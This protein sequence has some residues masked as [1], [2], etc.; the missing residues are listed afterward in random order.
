M[1][2]RKPIIVSIILAVVAAAMLLMVSCGGNTDSEAYTPPQTYTMTFVTDGGTEIEPISAIG[3]SMIFAPSNPTKQGSVFSGWYT[4]DKFTGD[5]V[6]IPGIMPNENVTYYAKFD[7]PK[8]EYS[9]IYEFNI[10]KAPHTGE[11][12]NV[13]VEAGSAVTVAD[14]NDYGAVGYMFMGWSIY[15]SGL[16]TDVKQEGQYNPGDEITVTDKNITLY[17]QWAVEY[18]DLRGEN[19]DKIYVYAPMI[20]RGLEA[21]KL[22]RED[23]GDKKGFVK[24]GF[25]ESAEE[26]ASGYDEFTFF[27]VDGAE[28]TGRLY[29]TRKY[30]VADGMQGQYAQYDYT[31][32]TVR[33]EYRMALDGFGYA[34]YISLAGDTIYVSASGDYEYDEEHDDYEFTFTEDTD[35]DD[36][37]PRVTY[38]NIVKCEVKDTEFVGV[39]SLLGLESNAYVNNDGFPYILDL[40]GYGGAQLHVF[41]DEGEEELLT[42]DGRYIGTDY[43]ESATVGEWQ[44]IPDEISKREEYGI[45]F[46]L[47]ILM[48]SQTQYYNVFYICD[49]SVAGTYASENSGDKSTLYIDGYGMA[50]Y[51]SNGVLYVGLCSVETKNNVQV[52]TFEELEENSSGNLV[53][54]GKVMVFTINNGKFAISKDGL[55]I[56]GGVLTSYSGKSTVVEIPDDVT[57]IDADA[58]NY[59]NTNVSLVSVTVPASVTEIGAR[60]FQNNYTLRRIVFL[61][62][63]PIDIDFGDEENTGIDP[64]RWGAGDLLIVVPQDSVDDYKEAWTKYA[65]K[66]VGSD[67]VGKLPEFVVENGVLVQYNKPDDLEE[68]QLLDI[69]LDDEITEIADYVF[70]GVTGI[71]SIDLNNV[72]KV[73]DS[74][75]YGC[76]DLVEVK[77]TN[78]ESLGALA[79]AACDKLNNSGTKDELYLP[80]IKTVGESA[81]S[82]CESLRLVVLGESLTEI[83]DFAFYRC[84]VYEADPPLFVQLLGDTAPIMGNKVTLGNIA[85]RFKVKNIKVAIK[86][87]NED[88]WNAYCRHLFIESGEEKGTYISGDYTLVLDGRAV[89]QSTYV[90]MYEITGNKIKFYEYDSYEGTYETIVGTYEN[91]VIT[92]AVGGRT[93]HFVRLAEQMT[94]KT[95]DGKCTLVCDPMDLQPDSYENSSG[96][97]NVKYNGKDV[98]L[99][100]SGYNTKIIYNF[101]DE[102]GKLYDIYISFSGETMEVTKKLSPIRYQLTAEDGSKITILYKN[103]MIYIETAEFEIEVDTDRKLYWTEASGMGVV[104]E[105]KGNVYTFS[106]RFRSDTYNF[107]VTVSE[108]NTTF[109]Y[110]YTKA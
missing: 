49:E 36:A 62:E 45:R 60:A 85:F 80:A 71:G 42:L 70:R 21:A 98:K 54:S 61:A 97:A 30:A 52:V 86:C 18:T 92:V 17:A 16:V 105:Q 41:D 88:T 84:N 9:V 44:F 7:I 58:F 27:D 68:G 28:F 3:G 103:D 37:K 94:Y 77:F 104:A 72:T 96:Y 31:F 67:D 23:D 33:L 8:V 76:T 38:F 93:R 57:K 11:I 89:Y 39:F 101:E 87:F 66:I 5:A 100:V 108:D 69:V 10:G 6:E 14:G 110:K 102:D 34:T 25:V 82:G 22:V 2:T 109:T 91:D 90:W 107:T 73:G 95:K 40:N 26:S 1:K 43:F 75:F 106:F 79:F 59:V 13:T 83:D 12:D 35:E 46:V 56:T 48:I 15:Q 51:M 78:V 50:E 4:D 55:I 74:A 19:N 24:R 63:E 20:G 81:F 65:D 64:F 99:Y 32:D 29:A 47:D 53:K